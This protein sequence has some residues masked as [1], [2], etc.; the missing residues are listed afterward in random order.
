MWSGHLLSQGA[1]AC[2]QLTVQNRFASKWFRGPAHADDKSLFDRQL[3]T[4]RIKLFGGLR[5]LAGKNEQTV[6]GATI[7]QGLER[8][9]Q[10]NDALRAAILDEN[11]LRPHVRV[12]VNGRDSELAMGLDTPV[13]GSDEIA[14]FPPIAGGDNQFR[15]RL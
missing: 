12:M 13:T 8:I 2:K 1:A 15:G 7:R 6:E 11:G 10:G 14:V 9:C 5:G 3:E 4:M